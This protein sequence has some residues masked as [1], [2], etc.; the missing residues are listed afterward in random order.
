MPGEGNIANT[1]ILD[2]LITMINRRYIEH[3]IMN[4]LIAGFGD[5]VNNLF[6]GYNESDEI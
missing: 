1:S 6:F 3:L 4:V 5:Q 2:K